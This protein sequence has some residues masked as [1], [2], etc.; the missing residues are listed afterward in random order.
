MNQEALTKMI[1]QKQ[2]ARINAMEELLSIYEEKDRVQEL[3]IQDL[4]K[5]INILMGSNPASDNI[6]N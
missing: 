1:I 6:Q 4:Q 2:E 3:L 5:E